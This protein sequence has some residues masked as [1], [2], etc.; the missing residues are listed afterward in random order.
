[1][2]IIKECQNKGVSPSDLTTILTNHKFNIGQD[3]WTTA[4]HIIEEFLEN[5]GYLPENLYF[6]SPNKSEEC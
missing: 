1:M 2:D 4:C 3:D 5:G 6:L